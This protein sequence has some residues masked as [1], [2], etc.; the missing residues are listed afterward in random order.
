MSAETGETIYLAVRNG[1]EVI[2]I[3]KRESLKA[4]RSWNP[5]GGS[6][7]IYCVGTGKALLAADYAN[8][9]PRLPE[10]LHAYTDRT[11]T[12][13][14]LLDTDMES[15]RLRGHAVDQGE[16]RPKIYSYG[17][18]IVLPDGSAAGALGVSVPNVNLEDGDSERI[19]ALV[20]HAA[21]AVSEALGRL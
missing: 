19:G 3:D 1:L 9:R 18:V 13:L 16:F 17:A 12:S 14:S 6:A 8:L 4:I 11:L 20:Q 15:V 21:S 10:T 5:I 2:Y 7:P